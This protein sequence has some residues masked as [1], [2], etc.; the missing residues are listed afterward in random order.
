MTNR[1]LVLGGGGVTGIAWELGVLLGLAELGV[2]LAQADLVVGTS[3][4]SVVGAQLLGDVALSELYAEQLDPAT[5]ELAARLSLLDV[6][7]IVAPLVLPGAPEVRRA[8]LGRSARRARPGDGSERVEVIRARVRTETWPEGDL[9]VTTVDAETGDLVVLDRDGDLDLVHAVAASCAVPMVWPPVAF[10]GRHYLDGG[11]CSST[12]ADLAVGH[13]AV[14]VLAPVPFALSRATSIRHQ[15]AA[16]GCTRSAVV[17]PDAGARAAIGRNVLD[18]AR[19]AG[20]A[21]AGRRQAAVAL[22]A[23]RHAWG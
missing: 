22:Q 15:L 7:R 4:G 8:R 21:R 1:A 14:V 16:T 20:S 18:P 13:D 5:T 3:A 17:A 9:R 6:A 19:R 12:N 11:T 2:D 23:V 10:G